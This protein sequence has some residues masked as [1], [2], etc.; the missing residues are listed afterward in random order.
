MVGV[1]I[2]PTP[3]PRV[4]GSPRVPRLS[5][6]GSWLAQDEVG[7]DGSALFLVTIGAC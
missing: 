2:P 4:R 1:A 6:G 5:K 7:L 3:I